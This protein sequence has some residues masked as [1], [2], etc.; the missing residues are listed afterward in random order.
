VTDDTLTWDNHTDQPISRLN[1][2]C[3]AISAVKATSRKALRMLNFPYVHSII[4][5]GIILGGNTPKS[6]KI[7]RMGGELKN[8]T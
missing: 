1:S 2:A 7:F 8:Y 5:Y 6:I 3:Y 4:P